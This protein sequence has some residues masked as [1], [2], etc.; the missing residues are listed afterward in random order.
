MWRNGRR[1]GLKIR[2]CESE[3]WV[4]IPSSA[5]LKRHFTGGNPRTL[6]PQPIL[7]IRASKRR[8]LPAYLPSF[9]RDLVTDELQVP[10]AAFVT[11]HLG[12]L[13]FRHFWARQVTCKR[14]PAPVR[15]EVF[16]R[17]GKFD[18]LRN[19]PSTATTNLL[20]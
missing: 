1:N 5:P 9:A 12:I 8:G 11:N 3:V 16:W 7:D 14:L 19:A 6:L 17:S 15:K 2:S 4:R 18:A 20:L 13:T 10:K